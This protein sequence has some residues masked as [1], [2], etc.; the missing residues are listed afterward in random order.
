MKYVELILLALLGSGG[1]YLLLDW[2]V[3]YLRNRKLVKSLKLEAV[4]D[5]A[6]SFAV[7]AAENY[8]RARGLSG[9]EKF[10]KAVEMARERLLSC[11]LEP[12]DARLKQS[13]GATYEKL[14]PTLKRPEEADNAR[15]DSA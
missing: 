2:L 12:Q 9:T 14:R 6:A 15:T 5:W 7:R 3:E 11:G 8:G 4:I 1:F 13:I 10:V